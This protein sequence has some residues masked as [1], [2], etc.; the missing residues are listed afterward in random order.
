MKRWWDRCPRL[1]FFH[2]VTLMNKSAVQL[3]DIM[4]DQDN[5]SFSLSLYFDYHNLIFL[6]FL[7]QSDNLLMLTVLFLELSHL[8]DNTS[9][10]VVGKVNLP[11]PFS[12]DDKLSS[13]LPLHCIR[14]RKE[15][16]SSYTLSLFQDPFC[17]RG[18]LSDRVVWCSLHFL[19]RKVLK[20]FY[21]LV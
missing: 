4:F 16:N 13:S 12:K 11:L 15:W 6:M 9:F 20:W 8:K 7:L 1:A 2:H 10:G 18:I 17:H 3:S 14:H 21:S 5:L 19:I